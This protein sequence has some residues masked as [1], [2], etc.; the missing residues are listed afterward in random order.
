MLT[1]IQKKYLKSSEDN[2]GLRW[3]SDEHHD[4]FVWL[5]TNGKI[6]HIQF[7]YDK[8]TLQEQVI[9]WKQNQTVKHYNVDDGENARTTYK[10]TPIFVGNGKW[11]PNLALKKFKQVSAKIDAVIYQ[12]IISL[13]E[14]H[15]DS[16]LKS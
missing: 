3:F 9:E 7:C 5:D 14:N 8:T 11:D 6:N 16:E 10:A 4:L 2:V 13:L 12:Q 1:E 15:L